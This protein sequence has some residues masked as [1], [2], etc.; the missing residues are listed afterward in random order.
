MSYS[1][2]TRSS[3]TRCIE[4]YL[5]N[6][7]Y[8]YNHRMLNPYSAIDMSVKPPVTWFGSKSRLTPKIIKHLV[9]H[10]TYCEPFGGSAVVLLAKSPSK[11]EVYNDIDGDLVNLFR[12]LRD[13][14]LFEQLR[15]GVGI[16]LYDRGEFDLAK[17]PVSDPV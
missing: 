16:T 14:Q 17:Q 11:V 5:L 15:A 1:D 6:N 13:P 8:V 7:N 12:V 10:Q 2:Q 4:N 9:E 3:I